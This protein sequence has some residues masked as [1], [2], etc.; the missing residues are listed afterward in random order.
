M[1]NDNLLCALILKKS[2]RLKLLNLIIIENLLNKA[3]YC[4]ELEAK[5]EIKKLKSILLLKEIT[6]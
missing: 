5:R 4:T 6:G 3:V 1:F 2:A